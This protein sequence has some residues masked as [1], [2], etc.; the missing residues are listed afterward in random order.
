MTDLVLKAEKRE[1]LKA[2]NPKKIL[3]AGYLPAIIYGSGIKTLHIKLNHQSFLKVFDVTGESQV[4]S[5]ELDGK[6][7]QVLTHQ[8]QRDPVTDKIIHVDFYQFKKDH[9]FQVEMPIKF[10]GESPAVKEGGGILVTA[11]DSITIECLYADL[12]SEIEV[13]LSVLKEINDSI[14]VA[15]VHLGENIRIVTPPEQAIAI[16]KAVQVEKEVEEEKPEV[17]EGIEGEEVAE[18]EESKEGGKEGEV[19]KP[20]DSQEATAEKKEDN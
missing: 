12:I 1:E 19:E 5:I 7:I 10:I 16:V 3:A 6:N 8:I 4:V 11:L 13:D 9:K 2:A 14:H 18:G 15:D 17:E 20:H